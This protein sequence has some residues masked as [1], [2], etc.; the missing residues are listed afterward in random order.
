MIKQISVSLL[1]T[2][3][4]HVGILG[5]GS[6][7]IYAPV[8]TGDGRRIGEEILKFR[9]ELGFDLNLYP[10]KI[11]Q[12]WDKN[13]CLEELYTIYCLQISDMKTR[14][15]LPPPLFNTSRPLLFTHPRAR[16]QDTPRSQTLLSP[17]YP[18]H[19]TQ[20]TTLLATKEICTMPLCTPSLPIN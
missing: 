20:S 5:L 7:K 1:L 18:E 9:I 14:T 10:R 3:Y 19:P 16:L 4:K 8:A 6:E 11:V 12:D 2:Q 13:T 15:L 17:P